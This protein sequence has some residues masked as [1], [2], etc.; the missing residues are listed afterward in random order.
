MVILN[1]L[2]DWGGFMELC[3]FLTTSKEKVYCFGECCFHKVG[4]KCIFVT[5]DEKKD[6]T[7]NEIEYEEEVYKENMRSV[8]SIEEDIQ[9]DN[10]L[11]NS[12]A[13]Y[14]YLNV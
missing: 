5:Y 8:N 9:Q 13:S 7:T 14:T 10:I 12:L 6:C 2:K 1:I 3:P 4:N 11:D